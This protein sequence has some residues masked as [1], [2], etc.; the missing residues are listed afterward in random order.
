MPS[1]IKDQIAREWHHKPF[2][3]QTMSEPRGLAE[4]FQVTNPYVRPQSLLSYQPQSSQPIDRWNVL[5]DYVFARDGYTRVRM[6]SEMSPEHIIF[7]HDIRYDD[8]IRNLWNN[9]KIISDDSIVFYTPRLN[10]MHGQGFSK[11]SKHQTWVPVAQEQ[12]EKDKAILEG[13][14][15]DSYLDRMGKRSKYVNVRPDAIIFSV[16][17]NASEL[18][19]CLELLKARLG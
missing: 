10:P 1:T 9:Y 15:A 12:L 7:V 16:A 2:D 14:C 11:P 18:A 17:K 13:Y 19:P 6:S 3:L 5:A 8:G 4:V